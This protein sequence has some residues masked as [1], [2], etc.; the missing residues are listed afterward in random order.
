MRRWRDQ[1]LAFSGATTWCSAVQKLN[2]LSAFR[3]DDF[4]DVFL[5]F[6]PLKYFSVTVDYVEL[7]NI[8]DKARQRGSYIS[9]QGSW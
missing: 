6:I 9:V 1:A 7:G 4:K 5:S 2:N 8:A 3:E